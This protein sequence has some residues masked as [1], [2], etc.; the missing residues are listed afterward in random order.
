[1]EERVEFGGDAGFA[2]WHEGWVVGRA[3]GGYDEMPGSFEFGG[4]EDL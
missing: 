4:G 1:M 3:A 2:C